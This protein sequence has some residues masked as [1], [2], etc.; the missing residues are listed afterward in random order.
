MGDGYE[1][2]SQF[3]KDFK[4]IISKV[5]DKIPDQKEFAAKW[6]ALKKILKDNF[7]DLLFFYG[8]EIAGESVPVFCVAKYSCVS[9]KLDE[10][11]FY[12]LK[13]M[14]IEEKARSKTKSL[15]GK[16]KYKR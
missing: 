14:L 8:S 6:G 12:Y 11:K 5:K 13:P 15:N 9:G 4:K 10:A 1:K 16:G 2:F 3:E 7:D